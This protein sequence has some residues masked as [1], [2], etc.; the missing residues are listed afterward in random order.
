MAYQVR[1]EKDRANALKHETENSWKSR[2]R[3][4]GKQIRE[5]P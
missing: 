3:K 4:P 5:N 1:S 2:R